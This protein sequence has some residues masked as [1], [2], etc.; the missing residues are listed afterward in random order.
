MLFIV[1]KKNTTI[2]TLNTKMNIDN[3]FLSNFITKFLFFYNI[4]NKINAFINL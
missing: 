4:P 3:Q 2:I 1:F